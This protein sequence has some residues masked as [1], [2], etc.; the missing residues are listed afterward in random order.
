VVDGSWPIQTEMT[1]RTRAMSAAALSSS[2]WLVCK[3]RAAATR[4]GWDNVV[5]AD[6][7]SRIRQR[8]RDFWDAGIRGPDF[9]WAATGP[10]LEAYSL[11]P[12]VKKANEPG[13]V[14]TV[15]EFL[16][17]VRHLVVEFVV[18]RVLGGS[19]EAEAASL[20]PATNYYLLHRHDFGTEP[21][22]AGACILYA[23]SCGLS[24][25]SLTD[26]YDLVAASGSASAGDEDEEEEEEEQE[27][28]ES[29]G[30]TGSGSTLRLKAWTA[31]RRKTL[32][33]TTS[34][35]QPA[36]LIDQIHRLM[37]LWR[38]GDVAHV[39]EYIEE[40][41]LRQNGALVHVLQSLIELSSG[42]E[43]AL[44]ESISNHLAALGVGSR[45]TPLVNTENTR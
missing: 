28:Q 25:R 45:H 6:M 17:H 38:E 30:E 36:P 39:N 37:F 41:N 3:K 8:L 21:A 10:A 33:E 11:H 18:G 40:H 44:L 31:R 13:A 20:D 4:A 16:D 14:L 43:R 2:V 23:I 26:Q 24:D 19:G 29:S 34:G 15:S 42:E 35:G 27:E 32:G 9:V 5:L 1:N 7:R 12:V 22:P